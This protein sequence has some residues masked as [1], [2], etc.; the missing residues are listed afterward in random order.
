[1]YNIRMKDI[2]TPHTILNSKWCK[3]LCQK[4]SIEHLNPEHMKLKL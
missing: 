1:M 2:C 3:S 4:H